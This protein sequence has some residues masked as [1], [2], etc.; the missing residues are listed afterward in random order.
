LRGEKKE[1]TKINKD[2]EVLLDR[3]ESI[4]INEKRNMF[5]ARE[6]NGLEPP[7]FISE[8]KAY[9]A[10]KKDLESWS[11]LTSLDKKDQV[12]MAVFWLTDHP[13]KI[14]EKILARMGEE[15][16]DN[17]NG[18]EDLIVFLDE[19]YSQAKQKSIES[20]EVPEV[21][22]LPKKLIEKGLMV[23]CPENYC[24]KP[25]VYRFVEVNVTRKEN[26]E[27]ES[28]VLEDLE[29]EMHGALEGRLDISY[30]DFR[31]NL[32][33]VGFNYVSEDK[34]PATAVGIEYRGLYLGFI[35]DFSRQVI[36]S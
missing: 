25:D 28:E 24:K 9:A 15:F 18:V 32:S 33:D 20:R 21:R 26:G 36:N 11:R 19:V 29:W 8:T 2:T 1:T 16:E 17:R 27:Q 4:E 14:K 12:E 5:L 3:E 35:A 7:F 6:K 22:G 34:L 23:D 13:S 31:G 10:Y 30:K